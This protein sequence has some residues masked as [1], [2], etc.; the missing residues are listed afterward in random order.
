MKREIKIPEIAENVETAL[1]AG[2]L[3]SEGDKVEEEQSLVEIETDKATTDLPSPVAGTVK[4]IKVKEGDEV[5]VDQVIMI[6]E[7]EADE[8]KEEG[9]DKEEQQK[10]NK[11]SEE[12]PEKEQEKTSE[13]EVKDETE[14]EEEETEA[15]SDDK[16][17]KL[18]DVPAAPSVRR[19]AREM[20][21]DLRNISGS[22]P[23]NRIT[24]ED[25]KK[26]AEREGDTEKKQVSEIPD[27]SQWG[28]TSSEDMSTIRKIT[29]KNVS[30]SWSK[31]PHVTQFDEA[32]ITGIEKFR[33]ENA[34]RFEKQGVKLTFTAILLKV[35][36]FAL[37][38]FP[39][40]NASL[41]IANDK[42]I[43]KHYYNIGIAVDT[44][45]GLLVPV[46][47]DVNQKTLLQLAKE[48]GE[49][50][51]RARNKKLGPEEMQGGNFTISNL[52]GIGGTAF[53][54]IVLPLQVAILGVSRAGFKAVYKDEEQPQKRLILP[55][56]LSYDHRVIDG[57]D[58]ARFLNWMCQVLEDPYNI[59]Q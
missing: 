33:K 34:G 48:M 28:A 2:I 29:S 55:L 30:K 37:Q 16:E 20:E 57:A 31:V 39:A 12:K 53:T 41:D 36:G 8:Q 17:R 15:K 6:I 47:R 19:L 49:L 22:G 44:P 56:S 1:V 26:A 11:E 52:G 24:K 58:G 59:L 10:K 7:T 18:S 25:V 13:E 14:N 43:Y 3:V 23:G 5:K 4:K 21:V 50:A 46:V 27:F 42:I 40:F 9:S 51:E 54:P 38:K 35:T 32:D 45:Q